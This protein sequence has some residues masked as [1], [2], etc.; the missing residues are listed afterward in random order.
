MPCIHFKHV[1]TPVLFNYTGIIRELLQEVWS[2]KEK[3][4]LNHL[5]RIDF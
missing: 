4:K 2:L 1:M 5:C 3:Y